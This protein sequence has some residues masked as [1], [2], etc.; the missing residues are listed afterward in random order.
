MA[1]HAMPG[2]C[3]PSSHWLSEGAEEPSQLWDR[4]P[5]APLSLIAVVAV[6]IVVVVIVIVAIVVA[7]VVVIVV[8]VVMVIVIIM[9]GSFLPTASSCNCVSRSPREL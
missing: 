9:I 2:V 3:V 7:A 8:A 5:E 6:M 4:N 1:W